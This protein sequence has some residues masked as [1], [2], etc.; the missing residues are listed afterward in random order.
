[1]SDTGADTGREMITVQ[2]LRLGS[3]GLDVKYL[4]QDF[5]LDLGTAK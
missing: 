1:M 4:S 2:F 3:W 5:T